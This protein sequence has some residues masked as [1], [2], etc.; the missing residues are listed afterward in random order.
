MKIFFQDYST[1]LEV[2]NQT[3]FLPFGSRVKDVAHIMLKRPKEEL[4]WTD[5]EG[6]N[7]TFISMVMSLFQIVD[8]LPGVRCF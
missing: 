6:Y 3:I 1:I 5:D 8:S 4:V 2:S 7:L